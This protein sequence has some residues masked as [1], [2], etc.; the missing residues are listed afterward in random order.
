MVQG[1]FEKAMADTAVG[2]VA[3]LEEEEVILIE[4][5]LKTAGIKKAELTPPCVVK[6]S[7][8]TDALGPRRKPMS[9]QA[10]PLDREVKPVDQQHQSPSE[11]SVQSLGRRGG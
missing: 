7:F 1:W 8:R 9:G 6:L 5:T 3:F 11:A 2:D 4:R 10:N